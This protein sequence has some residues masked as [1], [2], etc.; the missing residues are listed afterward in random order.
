MSRILRL[1]VLA[2]VS[3][4]CGEHAVLPIPAGEDSLAGLWRGIYSIE[5][6][7]GSRSF[8]V[9]LQFDV[10]GRF[11]LRHLSKGNTANGTYSE[12][13]TAQN[14]LINIEENHIAAFSLTASTYKF[15]Y[16][17]LRGKLN[18]Y[19]DNSRYQLIR[20][21]DDQSVE[22]GFDGQWSCSHEDEGFWRFLIHGNSLLMTYT[23]DSGIS[24]WVEGNVVYDVAGSG[25]NERRAEIQ[26]VQSTPPLSITSMMAIMTTDPKTGLQTLALVK[27]QEGDQLEVVRD[28]IPCEK[29][30]PQPEES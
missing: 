26:L 30:E 15:S 10:E 9:D 19:S 22:A 1:L 6:N 29:I 16:L 13:K 4:G 11:T 24:H 5:A 20:Q 17:M 12:Q 27:P 23:A 25:E 8:E 3:N 18:L 2:F 14:L 28:W 21:L 7:G